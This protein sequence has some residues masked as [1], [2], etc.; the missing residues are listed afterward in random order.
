[1]FK[2]IMIVAVAIL[3]IGW[4]AYAIYEMKMR[5]EEKSKPREAS[6]HLQQTRNDVADYA[7]KLA[8]FKKPTREPPSQDDQNKPG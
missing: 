8:N 7:K 3:A 2:I 1:M 6:K 4:I 5:R